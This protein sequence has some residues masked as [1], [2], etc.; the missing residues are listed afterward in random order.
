MYAWNNFDTNLWGWQLA[1][2]LA[3]TFL[4]GLMIMRYAPGGE[5]TMAT[6][7]AVSFYAVLAKENP[8]L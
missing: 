2:Y 7:L 8:T 6:F 4:I 1:V 5:G 3:V